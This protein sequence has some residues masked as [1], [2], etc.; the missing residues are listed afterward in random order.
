MMLIT[1]ELG[2]TLNVMAADIDRILPTDSFGRFAVLAAS[3]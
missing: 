2:E 1:E 3:D